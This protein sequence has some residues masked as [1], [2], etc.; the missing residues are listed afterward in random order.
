MIIT[1]YATQS[2]SIKQQIYV[3]KQ[4]L[5][6]YCNGKHLLLGTVKDVRNNYCTVAFD[7]GIK[8]DY[9]VDI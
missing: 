3:E 9:K 5:A 6:P 4:F 8:I 7:N 2:T 1:E